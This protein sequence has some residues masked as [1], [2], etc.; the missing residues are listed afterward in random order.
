MKKEG[1]FGPFRWEQGIC[2]AGPEPRTLI[3]AENH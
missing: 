3:Q 2:I 1:D